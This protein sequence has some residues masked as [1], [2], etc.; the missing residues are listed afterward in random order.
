MPSRRSTLGR[1]P[2]SL[3]A[4]SILSPQFLAIIAILEEVRRGSNLNSFAKLGKR[5]VKRKIPIFLYIDSYLVVNHQMSMPMLRLN[6]AL[7]HC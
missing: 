3:L 6:P 7:V 5:K 1:Y 4:F 2:I